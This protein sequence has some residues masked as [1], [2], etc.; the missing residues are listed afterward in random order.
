M[1]NYFLLIYLSA[2]F[3]VVVVVAVAT[4]P[5][6]SPSMNVRIE[7]RQYHLSQWQVQGMNTDVC[8]SFFLSFFL[9]FFW[10]FSQLWC[11]VCILNF[12]RMRNL[13]RE[14]CRVHRELIK[15]RSTVYT[16]V[17]G[18]WL[19]QIWL[20]SCLLSVPSSSSTHSSVPFWQLRNSVCVYVCKWGRVLHNYC[21]IYIWFV[22]RYSWHLFASVK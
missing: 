5:I 19:L 20:Y 22:G 8:M 7:N 18:W 9:F 6:N 17:N 2:L 12:H 14:W 10:S 11:G 1:G 16:I 21:P 3:S 4:V 15:M 13:T